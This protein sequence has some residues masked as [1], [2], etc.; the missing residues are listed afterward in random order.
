TNYDGRAKLMI[1]EDSCEIDVAAFGFE[2]VRVPAPPDVLQVEA[3]LPTACVLELAMQSES[4]SRGL[5]SLIVMSATP[6]FIDEAKGGPNTPKRRLGGVELLRGAVTTSVSLTENRM[7]AWTL[8]G[9]VP[10]QAIRAQLRSDGKVLGTTEIAPMR[11]GERREVSLRLD[12][13]SKPLTV[14][15]LSPDG[16]PLQGAWV[17]MRYRSESSNSS[18]VVKFPSVLGNRGELSVWKA[19]FAP[20]TVILRSIPSD[21]LDVRLDHPL[22]VEVDIVQSDGSPVEGRVNLSCDEEDIG[23]GAIT[24]GGARVQVTRLAADRFRVEG[25]PAAEITLVAYG[26]D[27]WSRQLHDARIPNARIVLGPRTEQ[28]AVRLD[29]TFLSDDEAWAVAIAETGDS[30]D[31]VRE[32]F[33]SRL[34]SPDTALATIQGVARGPHELWLETRSSSFP[35]EWIRIGSATR[36]VVGDELTERATLEWRVPQ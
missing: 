5:S 10:G 1:S 13:S 22:S 34:A 18:G 21:V 7:D 2:A 8:A 27:C 12:E 17:S 25:L 15:V 35:H 9:L 3:T 14:R 4:E 26:Q 20:K 31:I 33:S 19:G 16:Q 30:R 32:T 28:I 29:G 23:T 24:M 11:P 6:L 36:V